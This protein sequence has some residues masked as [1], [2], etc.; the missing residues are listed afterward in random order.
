MAK[1]EDLIERLLEVS[2]SVPEKKVLLK[3]LDIPVRL[4]ALSPNEVFDLK[5]ACTYRNSRTGYEFFEEE[6]FYLGLIVRG[7]IE[8]DWKD[9]R[10]LDKFSV[11]SGED[12]VKK[13][14]LYGEV[15]ELA[16][17]ILELSGINEEVEEIKN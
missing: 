5:R 3:R 7:S 13:L 15:I 6:K 4:K 16:N 10:L 8:P 1:S 2:V 9:K 17:I 12:V 14:L 11:P